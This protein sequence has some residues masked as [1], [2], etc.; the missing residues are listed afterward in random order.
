MLH[1]KAKKSGNWSNYRFHQKECRRTMRKAE[2][3]YINDEEGMRENN[4]KPFWRYVKARRQDNIGVAP[5]KEG[6]TLPLVGDS[7]SKTKILV[8]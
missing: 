1:K 5:L 3:Q 8:K 7:V 6:A 4:T 2:Q